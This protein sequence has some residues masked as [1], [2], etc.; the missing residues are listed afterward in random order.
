MTGPWGIAITAAI[1]ALTYFFTQTEVG[2][3]MWANFTKFLGEAWENIIKFFT[4]TF[5]G[6]VEF[7][8]P[9]IDPFVAVFTVA[10][11]IMRG[12]FEIFSAILITG[13]VVMFNAISDTIK[14]VSGWWD[15]NISKPVSEAW[16]GMIGGI[17]TAWNG[18]VKII[19]PGIKNISKWFKDTFTPII[20]W[21]KTVI[22]NP[23][24]K[25]VEGFINMFVDGLNLM[26]GKINSISVP[27]DPALRGLFGGAKKLGFNIK[28]VQKVTLTPLA[29]GGTVKATPGGMYAQIGEAGRDERVEPLDASGLSQRDRAMIELLA[30]R[31]QPSTVTPVTINVY[32]SEGMD[33]RELAATVSRVLA[34]Q[35]RKGAVR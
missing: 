23:L 29:E 2:K 26:I 19:E 14:K 33:E 34:L 32:P 6:F 35:L 28:P 1:G 25:L 15:E 9:L 17:K 13:F 11:D 20:N 22:I 5:N 31:D 10:F 7:F 3:E 18:F 27:I 12:S 24:I 16:N 4:D 21:F 8:K 30:K